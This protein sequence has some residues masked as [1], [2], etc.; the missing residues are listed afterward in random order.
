VSNGPLPFYSRLLYPP[1]YRPEPILAS[2]EYTHL[3]PYILHLVALACREHV[4][5]WY[6][7][8]T[9]D[10]TFFY[11]IT[12]T[13][14]QVIRSLEA[15]LASTD[16]TR[17]LAFDACRI[18][19]EH[20]ADFNVASSKQHSIPDPRLLAHTFD[21]LQPHL[22]IHLD[23]SPPLGSKLPYVDP[24][25]LDALADSVLRIL[26]PPSQSRSD[27]ERTIVR[28]LIVRVVL[29]S[30][31]DKIARPWFI[32]RLIVNL[33]ESR[34][35]QQQKHAA[36][37]SRPWWSKA[38]SIFGAVRASSEDAGPNLDLSL[39]ILNLVSVM[40]KASERPVVG[41]LAWLLRILCQLG[42][43]VLNLFVSSP[44]LQGVFSDATRETG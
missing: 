24:A 15:R 11:H 22:A 10:R 35:V 17:L 12:L 44:S 23:P 31:F 16:L 1:N 32:H 27:L 30:V 21:S 38:Y 8:L 6:G 25:Y 26:L 5:P 28:D 29:G 40:L 19:T 43:P 7:R 33:L 13:I 41:Q 34:R 4:Q 20:Y 14:T 9:R 2:P 18:L 42:R 37:K 39:P 36:I 3:S